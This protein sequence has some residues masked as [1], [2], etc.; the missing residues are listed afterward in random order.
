MRPTRLP[1]RCER[2][3]RPL[4]T[5]WADEPTRRGAS[6]TG[7]IAEIYGS[8]CRASPGAVSVWAHL[9]PRARAQTI[10]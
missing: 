9:D 5:I 2:G 6:V 1:P 7:S 8:Y 4:T 3:G 10:R